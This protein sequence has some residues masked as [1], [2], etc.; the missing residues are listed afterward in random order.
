MMQQLFSLVNILLG[1]NAETRKRKLK[2]RTYKVIPLTPCAGLLEW[3][4]NTMPI[5]EYLVGS[6]LDKI[7]CAHVRYHPKDK[8]SLDAR[9]EMEAA[10]EKNK[11]RKFREICDNFNP[12]FH[13]FF[14]ETF[15]DPPEWFEKRLTYI[16]SC[17]SN[18]IVGN[19]TFL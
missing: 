7:N 12:V 9:R 16:R 5:G 6:P 17:A 4:E 13:H 3:V 18:S 10:I 1:E 14:L 2:I 15:P 11:H 19:A 8:I